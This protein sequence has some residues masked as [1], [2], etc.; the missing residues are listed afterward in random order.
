[1]I[2]FDEDQGD[3]VSKQIAPVLPSLVHVPA[4][5]KEVSVLFSPCQPLTDVM[6]SPASW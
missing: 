4:Q 3:G 6:P 2:Y 1:M 5:V